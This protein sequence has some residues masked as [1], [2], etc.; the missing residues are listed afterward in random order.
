[1]E[2]ITW[3]EPIEVV[4]LTV[5]EFPRT[6]PA[7]FEKLL[8]LVGGDKNRK[9][10]GISQ[11]DFTGKIVYKAAAELMPTDDFS[12]TALQKFTI[13]KGN[14]VTE[15]I[16]NHFQ[17]EHCI[18]DAF[19]RLLLHPSLDPQGFCLEEYAHYNDLDVRCLVPLLDQV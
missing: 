8:A 3:H 17:N 5:P 4:Y 13:K 10:Y 12:Q 15:Y 19:R 2:T 1:M 7:T 6:V 9:Y 18:G 11:P 14:Y 16:V